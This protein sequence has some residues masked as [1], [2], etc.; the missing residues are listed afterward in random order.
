MRVIGI[1]LYFLL[2]GSTPVEAKQSCDELTACLE[3]FISDLK[4]NMELEEWEEMDDFAEI[5]VKLD[6]NFRVTSVEL[7]KPTNVENLDIA[8]IEGVSSSGP[9]T[10]LT[11]LDK[12]EQQ[13][14]SELMLKIFPSE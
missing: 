2:L 14:V 3:I 7:T 8:I 4:S 9:F 10:Y 13:L 11:G 12:K 5:K 6:G 1:A